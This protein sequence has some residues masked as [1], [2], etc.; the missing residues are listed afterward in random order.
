MG[1][2]S[3]DQQ[4][5]KLATFGTELDILI[6]HSEDSITHSF[7]KRDFNQCTILCAI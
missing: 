2:G 3:I 6:W 5:L 1:T 4:K 7:D